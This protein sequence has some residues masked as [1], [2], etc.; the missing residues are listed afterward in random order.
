MDHSSVIGTIILFLTALTTYRGFKDQSYF[1][2]YKFSVDSIL[3][4]KEYGRLF[5]S[6][7]LHGS[8]LHFGFNMAAL[9]SFSFSL[10]A[11]FGIPKYLL[12]YFASLLGGNL[13]ALYIHR[14]HGDY[15]AI[16]ASGA[17]SGIV[18][19]SILL[20]PENKISFIIIPLEISS[21][22]FGLL[23]IVVSI[24]GIK[25]QFGNIGHEAHLGGAI[26]GVAITLLLE[27][28][29]IFTNWWL[30]LLLLIPTSLFLILIIRNPAVLMIDNYWGENIFKREHKPK[31]KSG[32]KRFSR[33]K[34][35][36]KPSLD[37]LLEKIK[38][39]GLES[40]TEEERK[41]LDELKDKL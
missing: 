13:L 41:R 27:P 30:I 15:S 35:D 4:D 5:S 28:S 18:M 33:R 37:Y 19:S 8:W 11:L 9:I 24:F 26:I 40:L 2:R 25:S 17:I 22:L 31:R 39:G 12:I 16:G 23:F 20:F 3:V 29:L 34:K 38:S 36:N 6:G 14:N 10:E 32:T 7:F 1:E 21:W